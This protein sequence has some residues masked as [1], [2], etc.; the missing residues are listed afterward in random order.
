MSVFARFRFLR[1]TAASLAASLV[2]AACAT[3][4]PPS[5]F[6]DD[7]RQTPQKIAPRP[8]Y[9]GYGA[10]VGRQTIPWSIESLVEDFIE[11]Q[12][13]TEWGSGHS[14]LLR[15]PGPVT[16][17]MIGPELDAFRPEVEELIAIL[18]EGA[19][20]LDIALAPTG[21]GDI[22]IRTAPKAEMRAIADTALCF[23]AP[24]DLTWEGYK[25][26]DARGEVGWTD[27]T[28]LEAITVFIP[29]HAAPHVFRICFVEEIMQALGPGNDLYRLEDSG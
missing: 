28:R 3:A 9:P 22:T 12:F 18:R 16:V 8:D 6:Q 20:T 29:E 14:Q 2:L 17:G 10:A 25:D 4:P 23:F 15:W 13:Q 19:P 27:I 24:V 7:G 1:A 26:A 11:L 5:P 21:G